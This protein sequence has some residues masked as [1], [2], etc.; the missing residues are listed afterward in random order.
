MHYFAYKKRELYCEDVRIT[1][2]ACAVGTPF[3]CY[4]YKTL[5][6]HFLKLKRAF[7]HVQPLICFSM[8]SN[9]N[10]A[11]LR[12]LIKKGAGLDVVSGGELF[13]GLRVGCNPKKIVFAGVG[14]TERELTSALKSGIL[15][16]NVE[17]VQELEVIDST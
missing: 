5:T 14:K 15:L 4:S 11:V 16:I 6:D 12:S 7:S 9:S 17:S 13:R 8:K 10:S 3:Y 2:I 1:D